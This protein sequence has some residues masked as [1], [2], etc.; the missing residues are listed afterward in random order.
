MKRFVKKVKP[1]S[2][3]NLPASAYTPVCTHVGLYTPGEQA[4]GQAYARKHTS[5]SLHMPRQACVSPYPCQQVLM[6]ARLGI[7]NYFSENFGQKYRNF[8]PDF[9]V[10][11]PINS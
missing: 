4:C 8:W 9:P 10:V 6:L 2:V 5:A 3:W 11:P 7:K 1:N